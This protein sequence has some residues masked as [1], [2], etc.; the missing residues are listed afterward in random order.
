MIA[1]CL[2]E[3]DL[4]Y[5]FCLRNK[6]NLEYVKEECINFCK[7]Q[8]LKKA[9]ISSMDLFKTGGF[10]GIRFILDNALK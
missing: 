9:L 1:Y 6:N 8:Q 5:L 3:V 7:N 10:D 2:Q 4:I